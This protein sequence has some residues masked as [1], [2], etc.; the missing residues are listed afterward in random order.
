MANYLP[1]LAIGFLLFFVIFF[2]AR[3]ERRKIKQGQSAILL[4]CLLIAAPVI[5]LIGVGGNVKLVRDK[6][7][8]QIVAVLVAAENQSQRSQVM[9]AI[10]KLVEMAGLGNF[11]G[12]Y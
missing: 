11:T 1:T 4:W 9:H 3:E 7:N 8:A 6:E 10:Q 12:R 2:L 5:A